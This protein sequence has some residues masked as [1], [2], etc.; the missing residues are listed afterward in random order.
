M[1]VVKF[2]KFLDGPTFTRLVKKQFTVV[3]RLE[4]CPS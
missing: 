4:K 2:S 3:G 1:R